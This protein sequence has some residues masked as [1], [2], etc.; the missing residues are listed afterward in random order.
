[1]F[2]IALLLGPV[3]FRDFEVPSTINFGGTQRLAVHR[4]TGGAR[5]ID[6][7]GRDDADITF[8]GTFTGTDATLRA[9]LLDELRAA[10]TLLPLTWDIFFY[11]VVIARFQADYQQGAWIPYRLSCT[12]LRDEASALIQAAVSL[13][14]D[15]LADA[16]TALAQAAPAGIDLTQTQATL[17]VSQATVRGTSA[18]TAA[19][20]AVSTALGSL[21]GALGQA[22]AAL[23][24]LAAFAP[25]AAS[26]GVSGLTTAVASAQRLAALTTAR[27]YLARAGV[28]L[29][30][31]ST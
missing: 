12:V 29:Q 8:S 11:T 4:L 28:N 19:Q 26:G 22:E 3:A 31:A 1:M 18:Y 10:G 2:G 9:R 17:A 15:V 7:L 23:P 16:G 14:A 6:A 13:G 5:V 25:G 27:G 24:G 21:D 30:N 20:T